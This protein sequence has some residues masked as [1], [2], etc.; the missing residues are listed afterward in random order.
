MALQISYRGGRLGEDLDITVYW[1][2]REPDRPAH[3]VSDILGAWRVSIPRDV[4]ASGTP[5][6]IV[7][8]NDAAAS[9]VQRIAA[10]DRELAKAER[11]IGRWGL[12]VT[13]RRAQ[14]RYDDARTSFLEAV[15]SA[16]AAYQPVRD[17][18]EARLAEREAHARE[19][20]RRA[21]QGKER[22]WRDEAARFRE[23]ERRQEVADR[24]LPGG[25]S[26]REMAASGDA[27]VNWP[28][29]VRS[30]VGDTSSWWTSVRA[31][32]RNRRANA[33]AVR[34]VTE[35]INGV[36][37]ALEETGRPGISTIRG[38]P[39]EVLCGWWIHFDWSGLPDTTRLRTPPANVPA[40]GLE[41]KDWHYQLYLP[42]SRVFAVYRSGEFGLADEHG[43][44][45]PSG[46]YGT[47]YTWFKRTID[48]F[49]EEL[50]RNRVIIFRPPGHDGHRSYPM[51]DHADPDVYEPYVEAVA[52]QTAAHFHALL[53]NRP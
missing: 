24:P 12:L 44:K 19:A 14:L 4:D 26:P 27:P 53:P 35:A 42:S 38:R 36:A 46:G 32:E 50:F 20:A 16:A 2:P 29:E 43:S 23:W 49:A 41:D 15:R 8:W 6:E 18:I 40:V 45:I 10:E 1:F 5:Q 13:R 48:Q 30:L 34:K 51:T 9:F 33:Q 3:Y 21:Y 39:S 37:A 17:V 22:Q 31:S 28:A 7:S 47:T 11:A 25:L 52:E